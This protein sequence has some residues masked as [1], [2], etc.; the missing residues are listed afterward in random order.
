VHAAGSSASRP[1]AA[2]PA[3]PVHRTRSKTGNL[4]PKTYTD[5]TVRY[6]L[7]CTVDEPENLEKALANSNWKNAMDDEYRALMENK[8]GT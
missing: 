2:Q 4:K 7:S 8:S 1:P 3:A 5:G 6:G